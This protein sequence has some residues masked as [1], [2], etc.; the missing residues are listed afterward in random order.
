MYATTIGTADTPVVRDWGHEDV[1]VQFG[2]FAA[3]ITSEAD[4]DALTAAATEA[5]NRW[6]ARQPVT[7]R[8]AV[9]A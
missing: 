8:E 6:L 3:I 1:A 7:T 5:R 4:A 9:S 2:P